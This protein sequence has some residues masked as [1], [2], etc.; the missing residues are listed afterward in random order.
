[1]LHFAEDA[2]EN[3]GLDAVRRAAGLASL[4]LS[5]DENDQS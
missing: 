3:Q 1:M 2:G 5:F 4:V